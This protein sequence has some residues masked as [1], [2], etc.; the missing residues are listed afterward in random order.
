MA[1]GYWIPHLDVHDPAGYQAY[2]AAT[3]NAHRTYHSRALVR[4]GISSRWKDRA[5]RATCCVNFRIMP[6]RSP[7]TVRRNT[8]AHNRCGCRIPFAIL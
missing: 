5:A 4:G 3:P 7:A 8:S 2:M 6:R 1:K